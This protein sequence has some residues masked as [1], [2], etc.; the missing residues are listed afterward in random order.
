MKRRPRTHTKDLEIIDPEAGGERRA[1]AVVARR[2]GADTRLPSAKGRIRRNVSAARDRHRGA[3][4]EAV[5]ARPVCGRIAERI[6]RREALRGEALDADARKLC[7]QRDA[8]Q[9]FSHSRYVPV[10][11]AYARGMDIERR[12]RGNA[13]LVGRRRFRATGGRTRA[14]LTRDARKGDGRSNRRRDIHR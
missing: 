4:W 9:H 7:K 3:N 12:D 1:A 11:A 13:Y 14:R 6:V 10:S 5:R 2:P 8:F